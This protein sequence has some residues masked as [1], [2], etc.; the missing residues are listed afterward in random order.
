MNISTD[1]A[2]ADVVLAKSDASQQKVAFAVAAKQLDAA[3]LQGAAV[4]SLIEQAV[5]VQQQLNAGHLDVRV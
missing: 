2:I 5:V 4:V 3:K 1:Q